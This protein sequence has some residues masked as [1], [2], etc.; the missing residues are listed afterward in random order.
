[1]PRAF[2]VEKGW[3]GLG[4]AGTLGVLRCAQDDTL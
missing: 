2:G 3:F 4:G 1:M